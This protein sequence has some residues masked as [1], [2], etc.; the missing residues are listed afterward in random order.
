MGNEELE[1]VV[2]CICDDENCA[3]RDTDQVK[4]KINQTEKIDNA[5]FEAIVEKW[6]SF[7]VD[8]YSPESEMVQVYSCDLDLNFNPDWALWE[9]QFMYV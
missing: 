5:T 6:N 3:K 8:D 4:K 7:D 1:D 9:M 2:Y